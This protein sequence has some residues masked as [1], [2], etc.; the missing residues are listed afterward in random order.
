VCWLGE[1]TSVYLSYKHPFSHSGGVLK[2]N[3][4]PEGQPRITMLASQTGIWISIWCWDLEEIAACNFW[5]WSLTQWKTSGIPHC[6]T[7]PSQMS[8][9]F[10]GSLLQILPDRAH[11]SCISCEAPLQHIILIYWGLVASPGFCIC[12]SLNLLTKYISAELKVFLHPFLLAP[13]PIL[14]PAS[15]KQS[16]CK[17]VGL[18]HP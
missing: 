10:L 4:A 5:F 9:A 15:L 2:C 8:S 6:R 17:W 7:P 16:I 11:Y 14:K 18:E 1:G 3:R 13:Q 12:F